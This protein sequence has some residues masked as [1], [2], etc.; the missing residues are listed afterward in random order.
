MTWRRGDNGFYEVL[1]QV[2]ILLQRHGRVSYRALARQFD[3]DNADLEDLKGELLFAH[4][5]RKRF[6]T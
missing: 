1:E 5:V 6:T 4:P 2:L 3:V